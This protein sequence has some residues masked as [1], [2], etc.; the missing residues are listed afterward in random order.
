MKIQ[1]VKQNFIDKNKWDNCIHHSYN[2]NVFGYKWFLDQVGKD[3]DALIE[4]DYESVFPLVW[5]RYWLGGRELY[6]PDLI[7]ESGIYSTRVLS[8]KRIEYF[9]DAIPKEYHAVQIALNEQN[10][11]INEAKYQ[12]KEKVN[13]QILLTESYKK[14]RSSYS[15]QIETQLIQAGNFQ[16]RSTTSI[17]PETIADFYKKNAIHRL[18]LERNYH[19]LL[20][21]MYNVLHRGLGFASGILDKNGHLLACNFFIYSHSKVISLV[22]LQSAEGKQMHALAYLMDILIRNHADRPLIFDMNTRSNNELGIGLG[23]KENQY[24]QYTRAP[25]H[26]IGRLISKI[27]AKAPWI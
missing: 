12:L 5:R 27:E 3:W 7:R 26:L 25:N 24:Y 4:G 14:I 10:V 23:A 19:A 16:L 1:F 6:Q 22:P 8:R 20:R 18:G 13:H 11:R 15:P 2:G 17:K 9:I 21:I